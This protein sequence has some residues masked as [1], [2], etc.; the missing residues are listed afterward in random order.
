MVDG[1]TASLL[2]CTDRP[3]WSISFGAQDFATPSVSLP[4]VFSEVTIGEAI[5]AFES[6]SPRLV[7]S[8]L[9]VATVSLMEWA[10]AGE[11]TSDGC[12]FDW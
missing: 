2:G 1:K 10:V 6:Q 11:C 9:L 8:D 7:I 4:L 5:A 3:G 12:R